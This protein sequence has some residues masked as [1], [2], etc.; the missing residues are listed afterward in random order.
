MEK[1][2]R[3]VSVKS[4]NACVFFTGC[5]MKIR[6]AG[7]GHDGL[8]TWQEKG[9]Q[10]QPFAVPCQWIVRATGGKPNLSVFHLP[11][12]GQQRTPPPPLQEFSILLK[13]KPS[14]FPRERSIT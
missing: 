13:T 12:G 11:G 4:K 2:S 14:Q 5:V 1:G 6:R 8:I 10:R 7:T 3:K 9:P